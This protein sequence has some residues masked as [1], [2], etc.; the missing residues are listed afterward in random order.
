MAEVFLEG[1]VEKAGVSSRPSVRTMM[2]HQTQNMLLRPAPNLQHG[3]ET[4]LYH[5]EQRDRREITEKAPE[6]LRATTQAP[7]NPPSSI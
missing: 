2:F 6:C 5:R 7:A 4:R 1:N 3:I